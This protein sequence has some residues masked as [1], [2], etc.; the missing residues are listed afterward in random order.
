MEDLSEPLA[1]EEFS[2]RNEFLLHRIG[3]G[4]AFSSALT[5]A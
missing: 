2:R 4:N 5:D 3:G 1:D